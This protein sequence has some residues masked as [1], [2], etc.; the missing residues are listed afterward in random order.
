MRCDRSADFGHKQPA[1]DINIF[2]A[3]KG[4]VLWQ[5][6]WHFSVSLFHTLF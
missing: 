3:R 1:S 5:I 2:K 6:S 4:L